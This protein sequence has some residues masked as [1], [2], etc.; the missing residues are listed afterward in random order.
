MKN[1]LVWLAAVLALGAL[2]LLPFRAQDAAKLLPEDPR[3]GLVRPEG[4][5]RQRGA[6]G[7]CGARL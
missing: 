7:P 4:L 6:E 3:E 2:K 5:G 1:L